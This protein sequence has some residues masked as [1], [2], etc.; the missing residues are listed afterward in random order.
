[1]LEWINFK[2]L[3][4]LIA[5]LKGFVVALPARHGSDLDNLALVSRSKIPSLASLSIRSWPTWPS[6]ACHLIDSEFESNYE[7]KVGDVLS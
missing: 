3:D 7:T 1:M 6:R 4:A 2:G 5:L